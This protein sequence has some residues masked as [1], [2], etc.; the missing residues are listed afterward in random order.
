MERRPPMLRNLTA[1]L[2]AAAAQ[3]LAAC[4]AFK[5]AHAVNTEA[6][7][8]AVAKAALKDQP[9]AAGPFHVNRGG[10]NW[11]VNALGAAGASTTVI[12]NVGTGQTKVIHE[13]D[14]VTEVGIVKPAK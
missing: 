10:R 11:Y 4:D 6:Q 1:L 12:V 7:A 5:P 9:A 14:D 8:I 3:Q 2:L 13:Q